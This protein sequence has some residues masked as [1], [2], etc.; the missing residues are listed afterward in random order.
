[1]WDTSRTDQAIATFKH[2]ELEV[3][4]LAFSTDGE[5]LASGSADETI[6]LW[7]GRDNAPGG[8]LRLRGTK[9]WGG[10][11]SGILQHVFPGTLT[12]I[13]F[14]NLLLA[15]ATYSDITLWDRKT[16]HLVYTLHV[17]GHHLSFSSDGSRLASAYNWRQSFASVTVWDAEVHIPVAQFDV[18]SAIERLMLSQSGSRLAA[19]TSRHDDGRFKFFDVVGGDTITNPRHEDISQV[20]P[21][22]VL[23]SQSYD[24][25]YGH[26]VRG[27]FSGHHDGIPILQIPR[28]IEGGGTFIVGT[29]MFALASDDGRILIGRI[30]L[31]STT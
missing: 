5:K 27:W 19:A 31:A 22:M 28:D 4:A 11:P 24:H 9:W 2:H 8:I 3:T 18:N 29:S 13:A 12:S 21:R 20:S 10:R 26:C 17:G 16:L 15:A 23:I 7:D 30:P 14:S 1:L 25:G 6:R